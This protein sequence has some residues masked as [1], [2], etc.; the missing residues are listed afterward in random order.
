MMVI[1]E[2][3]ERPFNFWPVGGKRERLDSLDVSSEFVAN[4]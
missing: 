2:W 1:V 4:F 3:I